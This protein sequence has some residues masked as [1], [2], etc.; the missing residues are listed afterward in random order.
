VIP[1]ATKQIGLLRETVPGLLHVASIRD[2]TVAPNLGETFRQIDQAAHGMGLD[3]QPVLAAAPNGIV[4]AYETARSLGAKAIH[5]HTS[6]SFTAYR[7]ALVDG[8][9]RVGLPAMYPQR[10][11]AEIGG[12][13]GYG[14]NLPDLYRRA[15]GYVDRI[16]KGAKPA[17][18]PVE[19]PSVFD[20]AINFRTAR[21]LGIAIPSSVLNLATEIFQ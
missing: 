18:L 9:A 20:F 19:Q 12:L 10:E 1:T 14:V 8:A 17:E 2:A 21:A 5:V 7:Q 6:P 13:L 16:L 15:A 11:F 4:E 3:F